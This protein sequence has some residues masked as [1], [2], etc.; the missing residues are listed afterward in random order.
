MLYC[1]LDVI[2]MLNLTLCPNAVLH[3]IKLYKVKMKANLFA[4]CFL[5]SFHS[6]GGVQT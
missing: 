5:E 6:F 3:C 2:S 1:G 4:K